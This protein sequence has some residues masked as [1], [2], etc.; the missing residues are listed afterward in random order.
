MY[1]PEF[2]METCSPTARICRPC[3]RLTGTLDSFRWMTRACSNIYLVKEIIIYMDKSDGIFRWASLLVAY[4][5]QNY[6]HSFYF[7]PILNEKAFLIFINNARGYLA[8]LLCLDSKI[9]KN[10]WTRHRNQR[11]VTTKSC[12]TR[13]KSVSVDGKRRRGRRSQSNGPSSSPSTLL[14]SLLVVVV[15]LWY[16]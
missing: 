6:L 3:K 1:F 16:W 12:A 14:L 11:A 7:A 9:Y 13:V 15:F 2:R 5:L 4:I 8:E 10:W